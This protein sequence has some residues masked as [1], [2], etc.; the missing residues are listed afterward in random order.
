MIQGERLRKLLLSGVAPGRGRLCGKAGNRR[1]LRRASEDP[2]GHWGQE[3]GDCC[4]SD[5]PFA[6]LRD[7]GLIV[8]LVYSSEWILQVDRGLTWSL[9][10]MVAEVL[11]RVGVRP[12]PQTQE[13]PNAGQV[14]EWYEGPP[15][16]TTPNLEPAARRVIT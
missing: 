3:L 11:G 13:R 8:L 10:F 4:Q 15:Q 9:K 16:K 12:M 7:P 1:R 6:I 2:L 5:V 14:Q